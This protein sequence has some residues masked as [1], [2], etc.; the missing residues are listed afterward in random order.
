M[1]SY[2]YTSVPLLNPVSKIQKRDLF[3]SSQFFSAENF[4]SFLDLDSTG[5]P[6]R[7]VSDQELQRLGFPI[8][9]ESPS[10][11]I[12]QRPTFQSPDFPIVDSPFF[13]II[14]RKFIIGYST[15]VKLLTLCYDTSGFNS[16][17]FNDFLAI[18]LPYLEQ[19]KAALWKAP[20]AYVQGVINTY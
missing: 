9:T 20:V 13:Q 16:L 11:L 4:S 5:E 18:F 10:D 7:K 15:G 1:P 19:V 2:F 12:T 3:S 17:N 14:S 8:P 6:V